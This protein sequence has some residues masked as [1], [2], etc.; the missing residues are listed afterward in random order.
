MRRREGEIPG[1]E[2]APIFST[3]LPCQGSK[4][5]GGSTHVTDTVIPYLEKLANLCILDIE[6]TDVTAD[7]VKRL[8]NALPKCDIRY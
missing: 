8:R 6:G 3:Y 5:Y 2:S 4:D 1:G 7:G